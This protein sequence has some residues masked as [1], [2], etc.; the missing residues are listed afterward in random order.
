MKQLNFLNCKVVL[1]AML[2]VAGTVTASAQQLSKRQ[3][4]TKTTVTPSE[5]D[6]VVY[7]S[8]DKLLQGRVSGVKV[9]SSDAAPMSAV[10]VH[11]RGINALRS[12][13]EPLYILNGVILNP[14]QLMNNDP[15]SNV[16]QGEYQALENTLASINPQDIESIEV[17]KNVSATAIYGAM[18][19]NGVV[20]INT[21]LGKSAKPIVQWKSSVAISTRYREIGV[22][23]FDEYLKFQREAGHSVAS[24]RQPAQSWQ[25]KTFETGVSQNHSLSVS[26]RE[27]GTSYYFGFGYRTI[28]GV[29]P[30]ADAEMLNLNMRMD[31]K[32]TNFLHLGVGLLLNKTTNDRLYGT[33][34]FTQTAMTELVDGVPF[35][36]NSPYESIDSYIAGYQDQGREYR[37]IPHINAKLTFAKWLNMDIKAGV[38]YREKRRLRW[39]GNETT[40][41]ASFTGIG[42]MAMMTSLRYN[43]QGI[44]NFEKTFGSHL[45]NVSAGVD[46]NGIQQE[47]TSQYGFNFDNQARKARGLN[48]AVGIGEARRYRVEDFM[49]SGVGRASYSY[50]GKYL[51]SASVRADNVKDFDQGNY[52][53]YP[54]GSVAWVISEEP[55]MKG[56]EKVLN[57]LKLHAGWGK[58]GTHTRDNYD[59]MSSYYGGKDYPIYTIPENQQWKPYQP[60]YNQVLWRTFSEEY[61]VGLDFGFFKNRLKGSVSAYYKETDDIL[62]MI[63]MPTHT[64]NFETKG[65]L[66]NKGIE[67]ELEGMI[68]K[69]KNWTWSAGGNITFNRGEVT[70]APSY[71]LAT[72]TGSMAGIP[73]YTNATVKGHS[74]SSFWGLAS[75]GIVYDRHMAA[76]PPYYGQ[77]LQQGDIKFIDTNGDWNVTDAD[78]TV[79][80]NPEPKFFGGL[81]TTVTFKRFT[82]DILFNG[83]YGNEV[84]NLNLLNEENMGGYNNIRT[85]A[86][87]DAY[88]ARNTDGKYPRI[89]AVGLNEV[90]SRLVENGSF[91][92]LQNVS[93]SYDIPLGTVKKNWIKSLGV[94]FTANNLFVFTKYKGWDPEVNSYANDIT[95]YGVDY[96]SYPTARSYIIGVSATF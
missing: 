87:R 79:I 50:K 32:L 6:A 45:L 34:N 69:G 68:I 9:T 39:F 20:I 96:G 44:L 16:V 71:F 61:N 76:T 75:Q 77:R 80:G 37:A 65:S 56:T 57:N 55:F 10:N 91:L 94:S 11:I 62:K 8:P 63:Y 31:K 89:N 60:A 24:S 15:L 22:L 38:D 13:S 29:T 42:S 81:Y 28:D 84:L 73:I 74:P 86:Y 3:A 49:F 35:L 59:M 52:K 36:A 85:E 54:A 90:C 12:N 93:L 88:S 92:R 43:A 5:T 64:T 51:A 67:V 82:L 78:R 95:R 47:R 72:Q 66:K 53:I 30:A 33:S 23:G 4:E 19:A 1:L 83:S 26:G 21:K 41:G 7:S 46:L 14:V 27:G 40:V 17:L 70:G 2:V 25:D 58:A 18:G 48:F